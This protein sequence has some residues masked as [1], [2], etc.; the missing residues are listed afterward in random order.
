MLVFYKVGIYN[1]RTEGPRA[2]ARADSLDKV[3]EVWIGTEDDV[4]PDFIRVPILILEGTHLVALR[5][6]SSM[7]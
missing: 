2:I 4:Q 5:T 1:A 3:L 7:H 6:G